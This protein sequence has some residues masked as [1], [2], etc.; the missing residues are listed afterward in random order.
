M[1]AFLVYLA[2]ML[3]DV[4]DGYIARRTNQITQLG[5]LLDPIAD[6]LSLATMLFLFASQGQ[7]PGWMVHLLVAKEVVFV[8]CSAAALRCGVVV[9]ALPVGKVTTLSFVLSNIARFWQMKK[10]ADILLMA[11][12]FLACVSAVWYAGVLMRR[13]QAERAIA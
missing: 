10:L 1:G 9:S 13:L 4:A 2:A 6:K 11:S 7:I 8:L 3:T 5:K 12:L